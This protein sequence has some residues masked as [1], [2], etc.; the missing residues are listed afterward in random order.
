L[1]FAS[2][3]DSALFTLEILEPGLPGDMDVTG[4]T[5]ASSGCCT[6]TLMDFPCL[7]CRIDSRYPSTHR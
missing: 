7:A 4:A 1:P 3:L 5:G 6:T 2:L